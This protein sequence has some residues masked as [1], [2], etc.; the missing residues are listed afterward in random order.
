VVRRFD[1]HDRAL[2][3]TRWRGDT[4][5]IATLNDGE[6]VS[7][8]LPDSSSGQLGPGSTRDDLRHLDLDRVDAAVGP[9]EVEGARPGDA[10][11]VELL[12]IR[13][14][15]WG[16][17]GIF[18]D[19]GLLRGRFEDDLVVWSIDD[20]TARPV[21]GFLRPIPLPTQPMLGWIGVAP[22]TGDLG[23]IPPQVHGGN[24]D[25][26]LHVAGTQLDLPVQREGALLMLG[27]PHALQGDGEVCGTGIET[28][29]TVEIRV[30]VLRDTALPGP[31]AR[32]RTPATPAQR[33]LVTEGVGP[34]LRAAARAATEAMVDLLVGRG[35]S[36]QESYLLLSVTGH[37]RISEVV[38]DPN[39]VVSMMFP[40][41][42]HPGLAGGAGSR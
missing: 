29:A 25:N 28:P 38:D 14:G 11:R 35:F 19:F 34:D 39:A 41:T 5:P 3:Q 8:A 13:P 42:L 4:P 33:W 27:D 24:L 18:R 12:S 26:R 1:G 22:P 6:R 36:A 7:I 2:Q 32:V 15:D 37:L 17:S 31:R 30:E 16:W 20:R 40:E 21:R 10:L 23:M 9:F